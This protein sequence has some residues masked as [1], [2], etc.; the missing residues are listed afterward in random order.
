VT[1]RG[2]SVQRAAVSLVLAAASGLIAPHAGAAPKAPA[3]PVASPPTFDEGALIAPAFDKSDKANRTERPAASEAAPSAVPPPASTPPAETA[4]PPSAPAPAPPPTASQQAAP[5]LEQVD[6][7]AV[8][9]AASALA[10]AA[11]PRFS[12]SVAMGI[13]VDNAGIAD[14][15]NVM[16]PSFAVVG[17][18]GQKRL[19]FEARLFASEAA[20][21]YSTPNAAMGGKPVAD[22]GAD[23]QAVDLMLAVRPLAG[24][25][26]EDDRWGARLAH[27][28]TANVG[29]GGERVS[30]ATS[31]VFRLGAV[32]GAHVDFPV[33]PAHDRSEL[34]VRLAVRRMFGTGGTATIGTQAES[35]GDT[36][37]EAL[38]GLAFVF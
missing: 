17:G 23:R 33:T 4:P 22:V 6:E 10:Q 18:I 37:V 35:I 7:L 31:T 13:S 28:L 2:L 26:A 34:N 11:R 21:R 36:R 1:S 9:E 20:G 3:A 38:A 5:L 19:G 27:G 24:W 15:R 32:I 14:H 16:V 25:N 30:V 8:L 12:M 29:L